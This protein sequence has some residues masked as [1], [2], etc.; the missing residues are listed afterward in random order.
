MGFRFWRRIG[1]LPGVTL[2]LSKS[3]AS[4][5]VGPRGTKFTVGSSGK[6]M[7]LG[8]P[9]TGMFYTHK[10]ASKAS[11]TG[12]QE[13]VS[14]ASALDL[15]FFKRLITADEEEAFVDG[16]REFL[17]GSSAKALKH[18]KKAMHYPE[19]AVMAGVLYLKTEDFSHAKECFEIAYRN[20]DKLGR[21]FKKYKI[22]AEI[23]LEI[24]D[25]MSAVFTPDIKGV[26]LCLAECNQ[27][28]G[29]P[30]QAYNNL[31]ELYKLYPDDL[32]LKLSLAELL[33]EDFEYDKD[34]CFRVVTMIGNIQNKSPI[35][36]ALMLYKARALKKMNL[37]APARDT[38]TTAL[39]GKKECS[40]ELSIVL[41]Y[42][43]VLLYKLM[44]HKGRAKADMERIYALN[45]YFSASL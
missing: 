21:L 9:G 37:L 18:F 40:D 27:H 38:L 7:S 25:E 36:A 20:I 15:G 11:S 23:S 31:M 35:H 28:L 34:N 19:S 8:L 3:G 29:D 43:R 26:L 14:N 16:C 6:R 30:Y 1:I 12:Y 41:R 32:V 44:G 22:Y 10:F 42:E 39:R 5:S 4:V 33:I 24:T 2:N 17:F 45:P 13:S